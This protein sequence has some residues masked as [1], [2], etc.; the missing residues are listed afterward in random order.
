MNTHSFE[1]S[2]WHNKSILCELFVSFYF[3]L[4]HS[5]DI[6]KEDLLVQSVEMAF[7]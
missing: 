2:S 3:I 1:E 7:Q 5:I 6:I 4:I